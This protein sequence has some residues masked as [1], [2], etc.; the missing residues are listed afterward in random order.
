MSPKE[1]IINKVLLQNGWHVVSRTENPTWSKSSRPNRL[2][3]LLTFLPHSNT[4][5]LHYG[6]R[7]VLEFTSPSVVY[8]DASLTPEMSLYDQLRV[9][10]LLGLISIN[11]FKRV[12][13]YVGY[14]DVGRV[15]PGLITELESAF[16]SNFGKKLKDL[17]CTVN[18]E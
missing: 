6:K 7:P 2:S 16:L 1:K 10:G 4:F 11:Q 13:K 9:L 17:L 14:N 3:V 8:H 12:M 15:F 18:M 5:R